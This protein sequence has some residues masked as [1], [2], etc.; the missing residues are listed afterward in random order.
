MILPLTI[1]TQLATSCAPTV[2]VETLAAIARTESAFHTGAINDNT[3]RRRYLPRSRE[4]AIALATDL[5]TVKRHSVDLG[6]MQV[7]SA[8]LPSLGLTVADAFDPC[9]NIAGGARVLVA[10]YRT[11][12]AGQD[13]QPALLQALSRYNTGHHAKGF[14]NGY[15]AKIQASA[16]Q[17][18]PA[19]RVDR[20]PSS[21]QA[22]REASV[23][24]APP[25]SWDVFGQARYARQYGGAVFGGSHPP[26][27]VSPPPAP[28]AQPAPVR[29]QPV[30]MEASADAAASSQ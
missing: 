1:F 30:Q 13:T 21:G 27:P 17:I 3:D 4:E 28:P 14:S 23:A 2:H 19:I 6:L 22:E 24:P 20:T 9:K 11:P 26:A 10:A 8:N 12:A 29:L 25:P 5:V 16:E 7:N 18:V 15:V